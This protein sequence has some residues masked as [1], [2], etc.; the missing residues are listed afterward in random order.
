MH[1]VLCFN[2]NLQMG[3]CSSEKKLCL[4]AYVGEAGRVSE[5]RG[6][7]LLQNIRD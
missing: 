7:D 3:G 4:L 6:L 5:G 1:N 2:S